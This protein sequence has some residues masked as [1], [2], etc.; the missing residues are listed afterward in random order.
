MA[1]E[2]RVS[3]ELEDN[4]ALEEELEDTV[5]L[6]TT[7]ATDEVPRYRLL[8]N[9]QPREV[10]DSA[11]ISSHGMDFHEL[12]QAQLSLRSLT[13]RQRELGVFLIGC[14]D[15]DGYLRRSLR[16]VADDIAFAEGKEA[17]E[18]E[19]R[20]VLHIIQDLEPTGVGARN[21]QECLLLQLEAK[22]EATKSVQLAAKLVASYFDDFTN[23]RYEKI[24]A[25]LS[26]SDEELKLATAEI[27]KLNPKPG[28]GFSEEATDVSPAVIPDFLVEYK[29]GELQQSLT[30][31]NAPDL[32]VSH[33]Y[34]QLL[35]KYAKD[36]EAS[37]FVRKK[38]D[39]ARWFIDA[40]QRRYHTLGEVM[41]VIVERQKDFFM[42]GDEAALKP[43]QLKTV[44]EAADFD[45]STISRVV[46]SK[47]VQTNFGI[48]PLRFF[49]SEGMQTESGEEI[50]TRTIKVEI[51]NLV[52]AESKKAPLSDEKIVAQL[53]E[54]G[55][56]IAR[57][58]VAKY[59]QML[60]IP[61]ARMRKT[62]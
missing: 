24:C 22:E 12:M 15:N 21:L 48:F 33:E 61:E 3:K 46:N 45:L 14:L 44:A 8:D 49:F 18:D 39:A 31:R 34:R 55:Y 29:D 13:A 47:Y 42:T 30:A 27:T 16:D 59:R 28:A 50:S 19:L 40:V 20:E 5:E 25:A 54:K 11:A 52:A 10:K 53:K 6:P 43:M 41:S 17:S 37:E 9:N 26:I 32:R 51:K 1:L 56:L 62:A 57:R 7:T 2:Q 35:K 60:D 58:T 38:I 4:P 36:K 23:K